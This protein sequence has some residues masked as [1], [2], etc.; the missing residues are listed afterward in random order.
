MEPLASFNPHC[1]ASLLG[2][3]WPV[4]GNSRLW[5]CL[6]LLISRMCWLFSLLGWK[7]LHVDRASEAVGARGQCPG[8]SF[9]WLAPFFSSSSVFCYLWPR[10]SAFPGNI[11]ALDLDTSV[12]SSSCDSPH[13][14]AH[15]S[16]CHCLGFT[17]K[18]GVQRN[19]LIFTATQQVGTE[20]MKSLVLK[21][22]RS[23]SEVLPGPLI[24]PLYSESLRSRNPGLVPSPELWEALS[25]CLF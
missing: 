19:K 15:P 6:A 14:R 23:S 10:I 13:S 16:R 17:D 18:L 22:L 2:T 11:T 3:A 4:H 7:P 20:P 1:P 21:Y 24:S 9:C 5:L 12:A 8:L 25:E